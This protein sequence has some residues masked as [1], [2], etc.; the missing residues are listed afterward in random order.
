MPVRLLL[1][2]LVLSLGAGGAAG[3]ALTGDRIATTEGGDLVIH[4]INHATFAMAWK[5]HTIYVDPMGGSGAFAG[6]PAAD[7]VLVTDVHGDHLNAATLAA[8]TGANT[9]IVAPAAVA[10]QLSDALRTSMSR[11]SASMCRTR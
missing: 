3:Q 4:P 8:V 10:A 9:A 5:D 1:S 2:L 6:L 7:L 11:S